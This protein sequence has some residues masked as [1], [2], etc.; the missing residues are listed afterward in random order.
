MEEKSGHIIYTIE[1]I[2]QYFIGKLVLAEMHAM[3]KAALNDPLLADAM[4]GFA[5][6]ASFRTEQG[7]SQ[8]QNDLNK[9]RKKISANSGNVTYNNWWKVAAAAIILIGSCFTFYTITNHTYKQKQADVLHQPVIK[10]LISKDTLSSLNPHSI[11]TPSIT[12]EENKATKKSIPISS[13]TYAANAPVPASSELEMDE[14]ISGEKKSSLVQSNPK[15]SLGTTKMLFKKDITNSKDITDSS[16]P[17][18]QVEILYKK[19][20]MPVIGWSAYLNY[21]A[22]QLSYSTYDNGKQVSGE[23]I[24]QF[25]IDSAFNSIP[26]EFYFEKSISTDVNDAVKDLIQNQGQWKTDN[27]STQGIIKLKIIF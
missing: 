8:L 5:A 22:T 24:V 20:A 13:N 3:E 21:L 1:D 6:S 26:T 9:L 14:S 10:A 23:M 15:H 7:F 12:K 4:E 2:H 19:G 16:G 18:S 27:S 25:K 17:K 11:N